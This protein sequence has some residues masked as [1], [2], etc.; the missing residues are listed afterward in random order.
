[1]HVHAFLLASR[2]SPFSQTDSLVALI[3]ARIPAVTRGALTLSVERW[4]KDSILIHLC[5][6]RVRTWKWGDCKSGVF[7][8]RGPGR[9][10]SDMGIGVGA[11]D[12]GMVENGERLVDEG[13]GR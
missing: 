7:A 3:S 6:A 8:L 10:K 5:I 1:M 13:I 4:Y 11:E 12:G 9:E 2:S